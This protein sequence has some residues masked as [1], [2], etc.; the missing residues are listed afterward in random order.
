MRKL[1]LPLALATLLGL[2]GTAGAALPV[3]GDFT[4]I[5]S[6]HGMNGFHDLVTFVTAN[7]G[8]TLKQFQFGTLGCEG[9]GSFPVG[10]DPYAQSYTLGTIPKV[11][12]GPTGSVLLKAKPSFPS[13]GN[14]VTSVTIK[15]SF[16][17]SKAV[18]GTIA[19]TQ[20][21]NGTSC[22]A[23]TMKFSAV[24]GTPQ[25]LGYEGP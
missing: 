24:P 4:G 15:A 9:T 8:R 19:V 22:T 20:T 2:T 5:T 12:V 16:T 10:V 21:E 6:A 1:A 7:G 11:S 25:S 3:A 23:S 18:S 14:V 13:P 17:S